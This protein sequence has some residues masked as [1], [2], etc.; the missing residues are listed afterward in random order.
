M[1]FNTMGIEL[2]ESIFNVSR[3]GVGDTTPFL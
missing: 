3:D 2:L 1:I